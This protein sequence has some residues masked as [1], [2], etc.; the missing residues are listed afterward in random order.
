MGNQ[1]FCIPTV[2]Y[3]KLQVLR[4][5][6]YTKT[7]MTNY[8][9]QSSSLLPLNFKSVIIYVNIFYKIFLIVKCIGNSFFTI[10]VD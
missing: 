10:R 6:F 8:H 7:K 9:F 5:R 3:I 4:K 1:L 2:Y